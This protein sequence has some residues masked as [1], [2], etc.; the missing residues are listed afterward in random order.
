MGDFDA[1][2]RSDLVH[3]G[4]YDIAYLS[5]GAARPLPLSESTEIRGCASGGGAPFTRLLAS[6][7]DVNDD[8]YDDLSTTWYDGGRVLNRSLY[9]GGPDGLSAARCTPLP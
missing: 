2:G 3:G 1:D 8:G 9:L 5:M 7:S 6:V 4:A